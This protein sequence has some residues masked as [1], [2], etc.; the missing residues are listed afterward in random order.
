MQTRLCPVQMSASL[1]RRRQ[2]RE[3]HSEQGR[4]RIVRMSKQEW[5]HHRLPCSHPRP[6]RTIVYWSNGVSRKTTLLPATLYLVLVLAYVQRKKARI[7]YPPLQMSSAG[8][9][10]VLGKPSS[11]RGVTKATRAGPFRPLLSEQSG[12]GTSQPCALHKTEAAVV[13]IQPPGATWRHYSPEEGER[14]MRK[15]VLARC[16]VA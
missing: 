8:G 3:A 7:A 15:A 6:A 16:G 11:I 9:A 5:N 4:V 14:V 13:A 2:Q 10:C 1:K 12:L